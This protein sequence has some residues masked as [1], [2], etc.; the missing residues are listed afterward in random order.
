MEHLDVSDDDDDSEE[1]FEESSLIEVSDIADE[2]FSY[3]SGNGSASEKIIKAVLPGA[4]SDNV[5]METS[6]ETMECVLCKRKVSDDYIVQ[7]LTLQIKTIEAC[8]YTVVSDK[9]IL[10]KSCLLFLCVFT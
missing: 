4:D 6:S 9:H 2:S 1:G 3:K 10:V 8:L 7:L 5:A